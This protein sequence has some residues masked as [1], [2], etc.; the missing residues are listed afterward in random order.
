MYDQRIEGRHMGKY[1]HG[2]TAY[3]KTNKN[4]TEVVTEHAHADRITWGS[5]FVDSLHTMTVTG[6]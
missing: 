5:C 1:T 6:L 3:V 2:Q 4:R